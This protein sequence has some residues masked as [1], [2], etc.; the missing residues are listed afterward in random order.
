V[1]AVRFIGRITAIFLFTGVLALVV[2]CNLLNSPPAAVFTASPGVGTAPL[3]VNF[4]ASGS[5]DADGEIV[6][7]DWEF[8]DGNVGTGALASHT[9]QSTGTYAARLTVHD[10]TGAS[11]HAIQDIYIATEVAYDD[12]FR[13][14]E[15][16][17]GDIVYF[18]GKIIQV[19]EQLFGGYVWR[20]ATE[21]NTYIGY[22]GDILWVNYDGPRFLEGDI[23]DL[24]GKVKGLRTYTAIFGQQVTIP[25]IDAL[26]VSLYSE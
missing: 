15:S 24:C 14:N 21:R 16:Y 5:S 4:N 12:L 11:G 9:Y 7:Y 22:I 26:G 10:D 2:G 25:E 1:I 17:I 3:T 18:R 8:G 19:Q 20:V 23:I 6:G 13:N